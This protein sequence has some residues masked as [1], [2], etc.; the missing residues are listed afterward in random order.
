M[1]DKLKKLP[2]LEFIYIISLNCILAVYVFFI[3]IIMPYCYDD[4]YQLKEMIISGYL[5]YVCIYIIVPVYFYLVLF[6]LSVNKL[7]SKIVYFFKFNTKFRRV[8]YLLLCIILPLYITDVLLLQLILIILGAAFSLAMP[9]MLLYSYWELKDKLPLRARKIYGY[10]NKALSSIL[11]LVMVGLIYSFTRELPAVYI[12]TILIAI[13]LCLS[14]KIEVVTE[15]IKKYKWHSI[16]LWISVI[17][18]TLWGIRNE[19]VMYYILFISGVLLLMLIFEKPLLKWRSKNEALHIE[20]EEYYKAKLKQ[21]NVQK[22][23]KLNI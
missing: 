4:N 21:I 9:L 14:I 3:F 23:I 15:K 16:P 22:K 7:F 6:G 19:W 8:M 11:S 20:T 12:L 13:F 17:Y 5:Q 2:V 10:I 18:A 1:F